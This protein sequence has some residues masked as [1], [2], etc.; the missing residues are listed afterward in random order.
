MDGDPRRLVDYFVVAGI[1]DEPSQMKDTTE[2]EDQLP[3]TDI[4]VVIASQKEQAPLEYTCIE[5][6]PSG[7]SADLNHG[8]IR[9][10]TVF[11]CYRRGVDKPPLTDIG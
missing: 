11:L 8:S 1:S 10:Q 6:T 3:I 7:H 5:R 2:L 9:C 4:A